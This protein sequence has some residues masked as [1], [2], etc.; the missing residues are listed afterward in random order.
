MIVFS[1]L[2]RLGSEHGET[3]AGAESD[4]R[5]RNPRSPRQR[6]AAVSAGEFAKYRN[7]VIRDIEWLLNTRR[8]PEDIPEQYREIQESVYNYG[9]P[10]FSQMNLNPEKNELHQDRLASLIKESIARFEPRILDVRVSVRERPGPGGILQFQI[11][12]RLRLK[13][14][15]QPVSF[16]TTLDVTRGDYRVEAS[17]DKLG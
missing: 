8:V 14:V 9:L 5:T 15:P 3:A 16:D 17:G 11:F 13:P 10:D 12:G 7:A 6:D 4:S 1:V 2:N